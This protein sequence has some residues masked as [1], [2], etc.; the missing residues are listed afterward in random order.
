MPARHNDTATSIVKR[1]GPRLATWPG[2]FTRIKDIGLAKAFYLSVTPIVK[3]APVFDR[4]SCPLRPRQWPE[5]HSLLIVRPPR[6][7]YRPNTTNDRQSLAL[8]VTIGAH[9]EPANL[10]ATAMISPNTKI[11][12]AEPVRNVCSAI[13][14]GR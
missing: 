3:F 11:V 14:P 6:P 9:S 1:P 13:Q 12:M 8:C 2:D 4:F 5:R 10:K 7:P